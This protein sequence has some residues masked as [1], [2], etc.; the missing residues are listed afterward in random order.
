MG[1]LSGKPT[2][3]NPPRP[4]EGKSPWLGES[5]LMDEVALLL[6]GS[7]KRC[8]GCKRAT[9]VRNLDSNQHCPDCR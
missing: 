6:D 5:E 7:A 2:S 8:T 4:T 9:H 3:N 1:Y